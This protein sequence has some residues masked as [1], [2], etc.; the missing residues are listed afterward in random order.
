M[1]NDITTQYFSQDWLS[2]VFQVVMEWMERRAGRRRA[3]K[4]LRKDMEK[5]IVIDISNLVDNTI[6][7]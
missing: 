5:D 2:S 3:R 6:L 1:E 4:V 7:I